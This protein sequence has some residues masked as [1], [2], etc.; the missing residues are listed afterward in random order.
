MYFYMTTLL[1]SEIYI[2]KKLKRSK[3][4]VDLQ[5]NVIIAIYFKS[6]LPSGLFTIKTVLAA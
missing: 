5:P 1:Q 4:D 3:A 2:K 6:D